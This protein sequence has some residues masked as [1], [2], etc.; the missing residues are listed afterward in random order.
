MLS[1]GVVLLSVAAVFYVVYAFVTYGLLVRAA[2]T[3]AVTVAAFAASAVLARRRLAG[4]AEAVGVVGVVLLHLDVWAVR[5]YDLAGAGSADPFRY[6]GV[7]TLVASAVLLALRPLL[8]VRAIGLAGWAGL[9]VAAGLLAA[10]ASSLDPATR[11]ALALAFASAVSL[12]HA[13]P[14]ARG[15]WSPS[16]WE[17]LVLRVVGVATA[18]GALLAGA[19]SAADPGAVPAVPLLLAA[20]AAAVHAALLS[21]STPAVTTADHG[22]REGGDD[23]VAARTPPASATWGTRPLRI[24]AS[25]VAG[26]GAAMAVPVTAVTGGPA[27]LTLC[28]QLVA[29]VLVVAVLDVAAGRLTSPLHAASA[30][31]ARSA[32]GVVAI[33]AALPVALTAAGGAAAA[34]VAG[35]PPWALEPGSDPVRELARETGALGAAADGRAAVLGVVA[36]WLL[37][38]GA[39]V[40]GRRRAAR[41]GALAWSG[42][43][44]VVVAIPAIGP[45]AAVVALY[46]LVAAAV[47]ALG[48]RTEAAPA[49]SD[50]S[51]A[52]ADGTVPAPEPGPTA[53]ARVLLDARSAPVSALGIA[54][55]VAGWLASWGSAPTWWAATPVLL[56]LLAVV[57]RTGGSAVARG[58]ATVVAAAG[59]LLSVAA[60][61]PS[62]R[63][64]GVIGGP[65]PSATFGDASD[66]VVLVL[67]T[68][69][70]LVLV[71]GLLRSA[72]G[73]R[74]SLVL[75]TSLLPGLVASLL[76]MLAGADGAGGRLTSAP[77][78][79]VAAQVLLAAGL[80]A[81]TAGGVGLRPLPPRPERTP[82]EVVEL[83]EPLGSG[84]RPIVAGLGVGAAPAEDAPAEDAPAGVPAAIPSRRS[85]GP[86]SRITRERLTR[87]A[88]AAL[89]APVGLA[90]VITVAVLLPSRGL[91]S[92]ILPAAVA[93]VVIAA[94]RL[95]YLRAS[96]ALRVALDAGSVAVG[97]A[98]LPIAVVGGALGGR[99]DRVW[100]P[101]V[102]LAVASL[103]LSTAADGLLLSRSA[104][105]IWAWTALGLG[106]AA[107]WS[108]LLA[109]DVRL[110]EAYVLPIAGT[111]LAVAALLHRA[112]LRVD[113]PE[114]DAHGPRVRRGVTS[115]VLAGILTAALPLAPAGRADDVFRPLIATAV[116]AALALSAAAGLGRVPSAVRPLLRATVVGG[117]L[118][119]LALG[120][121]RA[122]R[123]AAAPVERTWA[124]DAQLVVTCALLVA[125]GALV[126]RAARDAVDSLIAGA[127]I[128][129][130]PTLT[131]LVM[132]LSVRP[133]QGLT[134]PLAAAVLLVSGAGA[135]LAIRTAHRRVLDVVTAVAHV[136]AVVVALASWR[137]ASPAVD[138]GAV[139][140]PLVTAVLIAAVGAAARLGARTAEAGG[141]RRV[142]RP[143]GYA[144]DAAVGVL[145][146]VAVAA[147]AV[148]DAPGLPLALLL[149]ASAV[150]ITSLDPRSAGRRRLGWGALVLGSA[151]LWVAL[152]RGDVGSV[153]PYVLPPAGVLLLVAAALERGPLSS[154]RAGPDGSRRT[155]SGAPLLLAALLLAA[156]PTAVASWEGGPVRGLVLGGGAGACLILACAALGR[157][158]APTP[159]LERTAGSAPSERARR[160]LLVATAAPAAL[161]VLLVGLGRPLAQLLADAPA[162]PGRTDLWSLSSGVVLILAV[163]LLGTGAE[164]PPRASRHDAPAT[165]TPSAAAPSTAGPSAPV[166][167]VPGGALVAVLAVA[168]R[169]LALAALAG[170]TIVGTVAIIVGHAAALPG[171]TAR[172]TVLV[173]L[174]ALLHVAAAG[175]GARAPHVEGGD[176]GDGDDPGSDAA[177]APAEHRSTPE[178]RPSRRGPL[179]DPLV[180]VSALVAAVLAAAV[181]AGT[182]AA[183]PVEWVT[184]PVALALIAV[185]TRR[186]ADDPT[187][188]SMRHL[189]PGLLVL[190]VPPLLADL[191]PSP[192]WRIVALGVVALAVLLVGAS[193][194]LRAPFLIG[195]AVLLVHAIAQ[196]WPWIRDASATV[197]WWAWA[198]IGG[199]V[200]IAVAARY[201][202]RIRDLRE[203]AARVSALR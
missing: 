190:M 28:G 54:A 68:S 123:L 172:S 132:V 183:D 85:P 152:A 189:A 11:T 70:A 16:S 80:V 117:G 22:D 197:P 34:M 105:R 7:G 124:V 160:S 115:L 102:V 20:T 58:G 130:V 93:L 199:V 143:A 77:A 42:A 196:L 89:T 202:R 153:E 175:S 122:I 23:D 154:L 73:A 21:S 99:E 81:W 76:V 149:A 91:T 90:V 145:V 17:R 200:L 126:L 46:V 146:L 203:V 41:R 66:P 75:V 13:L 19:A 51:T 94:G 61:A 103:V 108:R 65:P 139:A 4:T 192:A 106:I 88:T 171:T 101:L 111:L 29:A 38:L 112:A 67:A 78:W 177:T 201:E 9:P 169:A 179:V 8:R 15:W 155:G 27:L 55:A 97:A 125:T 182:G 128:A 136:A 107:L 83:L 176:H 133:D 180:A 50:L 92:G 110:V 151:A 120:A 142:Q 60:L 84:Q 184:V 40:L 191:G 14:Q 47:V 64:A 10:S 161:A 87:S 137:S 114:A 127:A 186:M 39:S 72:P 150:L 109:T 57:A 12:L 173:A 158:V 31:L 53:G 25:V 63:H 118:G 198:G 159:T 86:R 2:I 185:G 135:L 35:L 37:V 24:I 3:G 100:I 18:A 168:P 113:R 165:P 167:A 166:A 188:G 1:I 187:A 43:V 174:V 163:A 164:A 104:R 44:V 45:L 56:G 181:L 129:V 74:R 119:L 30:R 71:A 6:F 98:A 144:A 52:D 26:A 140:V 62:L 121:T 157:S 59:T 79:P 69:G 82:G 138:T 170:V 5:A 49:R 134:R 194:R 141:S 48:I 131:A 116:L 148:V 178:P 162:T 32:A 33:V 193:R 195:G 156:V 36:A 96:R 147:T 95:A